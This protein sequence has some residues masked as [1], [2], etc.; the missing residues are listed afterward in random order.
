MRTVSPAPPRKARCPARQPPRGVHL[1]QRLDVLKEVELFVLR[2]RPEILPLVRSVLFFEI[3]FLIDDRDAALL[4]ERR[5]GQHHAEPFARIGSETVETRRDRARIGVDAVQV[6][7]HDA[8]PCGRR[9]QLPSAHE[10]LAQM[11]LLVR[12][13]LSAEVARHVVVRGEQKAAGTACRIA[14][15]IVRF[16]LHDIDGSLDQLPRSEILTR[17]LRRFRRAFREQAF[18]DVALDVGLERH[19][20]LGLDEVDDQALQGGWVLYVLA[21]F[22]ED[23]AQHAALFS[24]LLEHVTVMHFEIVTVLRQEASPAELHRN[25]RRPLV[26]RERLLVRHLEKEQKRD[27]LGVSHVREPVVAQD[28][29][30]IPG[31]VDD[32]LRG[33]AHVSFL[34]A[35]FRRYQQKRPSRGGAFVRAKLA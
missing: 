22:L 27:L 13:E 12:I 25:D 30:E 16:R 1:Q 11:F 9:N 14:N 3:A 24:Q 33:V 32:L 21:R 23:L 18:V 7:I 10:L 34:V 6:E 2:R 4:S 31:L 19:P 35:G 8:Q 26:G 29:R 5:I 17:A 20:S 15:R 28:V